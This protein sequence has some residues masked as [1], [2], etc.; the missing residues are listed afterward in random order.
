VTSV[1]TSIVLGG[2][3]CVIG[4]IALGAALGPFRRYDV[5]ETL[6]PAPPATAT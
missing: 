3:A 2:M 4:A 5:T 6:D 1:E